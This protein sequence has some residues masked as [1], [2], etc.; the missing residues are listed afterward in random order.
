MDALDGKPGDMLHLF[1]PPP[2]FAEPAHIRKPTCQL[3]QRDPLTLF[4]A[5]EPFQP[6]PLLRAGAA[7]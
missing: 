1:A 7:E 4:H 2:E 6:I 5:S 3:W